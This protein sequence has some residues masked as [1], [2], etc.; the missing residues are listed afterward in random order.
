[1]NINLVNCPISVRVV[2]V[3]PHCFAFGGFEYQ[4]LDAMD[5]VKSDDI[6]IKPLD[7]W[8]READFDIL[9]LWGLELQHYNTIK[10]AKLAGKKIVISVLVGYNDWKS[11]I[12]K[13]ASYI[14]FKFK[15]Q[16]TILKVVDAITVVNQEQKD[17]LV[18]VF[19]INKEKIFI[20]PNIVGDN[21]YD[22]V[23]KYTPVSSNINLENYVI[24][25]GNICKR[26]NQLSLVEACKYTDTPL[27]IVGNILT[28]EE[29]YAKSLD[30]LIVDSDNIL[31]IKG[32]EQNS[33]N[34][35]EA[36]KNSIAFALPSHAETQ[37]IS[38]LE[39]SAL[40]KPL[41]LANKPY[42]KQAQYQNACLVDSKSIQSISL[43]L[44][45]V[46]EKPHLYVAPNSV[47][48]KCKKENVGNM[49]SEVYKQLK[50]S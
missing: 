23:K 41:I 17:Y 34:L 13:A 26:K 9:H 28:G 29:S 50:A 43:G 42:G 24:C 27:L 39:A 8:N 3:Q 30:K 21:Y 49:Y 1:M 15:S 44:V 46:K 45:K 31:W 10:W 33:N 19:S 11:P 38:A 35:L 40:G 16:K 2:P 18:S 37:P 47:I 20:I 48:E 32:M 25:T 7:F 14:L 22:Y 6:N 4:M 5:A 12:K 36:Y